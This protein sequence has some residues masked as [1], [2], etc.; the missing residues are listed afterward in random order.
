MDNCYLCRERACYGAQRLP[1][2]DSR[3]GVCKYVSFSNFKI[4]VTMRRFQSWRLLATLLISGQAL[5]QSPPP[6]SSAASPGAPSTA[7][8]GTASAPNLPPGATP[9]AGPTDAVPAPD[10]PPPVAPPPPPHDPAPTSVERPEES[11]GHSS[12]IVDRLEVGGWLGWG[13]QID[14]QD[15]HPYGFT[16]GLRG[17]AVLP[18]IH[19]YV[20]LMAGIFAGQSEYTYDVGTYHYSEGLWQSQVAVEGGYNLDFGPVTLRP[21]AG[22][23][24]NHTTY[25]ATVN[26]GLYTGSADL[27]DKTSAY[28]SLGAMGHI[29]LTDRIYGGID[30][31]LVLATTSPLSSAIVLAASGGVMF[32]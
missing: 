29:K 24:V 31:R 14:G 12:K 20:G 5:A 2:T 15:T 27:A 13:I 23:G 1:L 8:P 3:F 4:G 26:Y 17:G 7:S 21:Y 9:N 10:A 16:L 11:S 28:L 25:T 32:F 6:P 19:V 22:L 30:S 18:N